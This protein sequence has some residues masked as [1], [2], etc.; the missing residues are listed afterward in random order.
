MCPP[1]GT[2]VI[3]YEV[4]PSVPRSIAGTNRGFAA[5]AVTARTR[6][7]SARVVAATAANRCN[8]ILAL[9]TPDLPFVCLRRF[10]LPPLLFSY[11]H[12]ARIRSGSANA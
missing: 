7:V 8:V 12:F 11:Q 6:I 5:R 1:A 2:D 10:A 3:Q 9:S 4:L